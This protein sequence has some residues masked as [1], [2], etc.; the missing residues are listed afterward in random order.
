MRL[1]MYSELIQAESDD[2]TEE[3]TLPFSYHGLLAKNQTKP[4]SWWMIVI[5]TCH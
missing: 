1:T 4:W 2:D 3:K 5:L